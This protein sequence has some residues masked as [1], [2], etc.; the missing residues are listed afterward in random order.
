MQEAAS[1]ILT[2]RSGDHDGLRGTAVVSLA[3]H[4]VLI[5]TVLFAP[6]DWLADYRSSEP[7]LDVMRIQLGG[8]QGPGQG[9]RTALGGRPIQDVVPLPEIRRPQ[10]IQPPTAA[11]PKMILPVP[12][13]IPAR[14]P[15]P[16]VEV[17]TAPAE[18]RGR[19]PTR[20][21]EAREGSTMAD[22]GVQGTGV[23]LSGGGLGGNGAEIDVGDFCCPS[24]LS[25]MLEAI[26]RRW[27]EN[28]RVT[29][30]VVVRFTVDRSGAIGGVG[31]DR[32]SGYL[33]LDMSAERAVLLTRALPPLPPDHPDDD[34]PVRLT[35]EYQP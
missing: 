22:T 8:P 11:P 35:F 4:A 31:V 9:G 6:A 16:E 1:E 33:A 7:A 19:T 17:E 20:G 34:L 30:S 27:D 18:A 25:L 2:A 29:G 26:R 23:G 14:R 13:A 5:T 12:E 28:Q 3:A 21:P 15:E 32:S 24:Y 10:W